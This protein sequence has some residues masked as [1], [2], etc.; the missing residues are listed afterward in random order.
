MV[1]Y[2]VFYGNKICHVPNTITLSRIDQEKISLA[3][4]ARVISQRLLVITA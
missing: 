1:K 3:F 2:V 4:K